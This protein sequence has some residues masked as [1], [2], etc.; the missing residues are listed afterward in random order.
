MT[1][2]AAFRLLPL[3]LTICHASA[4]NPPATMRERVELTANWRLLID[5]EDLGEKEQWYREGFD[6]SRWSKVTV[7][8]AWDL[9]DEGLW[10]YEGIGWYSTTIAPALARSGR[11]QRL[12]F[13]RVMYFTKAWLNGEALGENLGGYLPFEFEVTGRL[14][15]DQPNVLVLRVDNRSRLD[16]LPAS[17]N[18]EWMQYGGILQPVVLETTANAYL[19]GVTI[20]AVPEGSG[21]IVDCE[22]EV[23]VPRDDGAGSQAPGNRGW[24]VTRHRGCELPTAA[25]RDIAS[26]PPS[27]ARSLQSMEP[28]NALS[29]H[30]TRN[31]RERRQG[32]GR[33]HVAIW[34]AEDRDPRPADP[35][36]RRAHPIA[37]RQPLR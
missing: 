5:V 25:R 17:R 35:A 24:V 27:E 3:F 31:D 14:R 36:Q 1:T 4:A 15:A 2:R 16:W 32:R 7:P 29:V 10:G 18:I 28:A 13:G 19:A 20:H 21:A 33:N 6:Y 8:K 9:H 30:A 11:L 37:G 22:V 26:A 23:V 34:S 12:H